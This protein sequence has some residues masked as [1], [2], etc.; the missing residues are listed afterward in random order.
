MQKNQATNILKRLADW[1]PSRRRA[2]QLQA[3][4]VRSD[5]LAEKMAQS[6]PKGVSAAEAVS[7]QRR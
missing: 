6:W 7:K 4:M 3:A 2:K 5:I 1:I